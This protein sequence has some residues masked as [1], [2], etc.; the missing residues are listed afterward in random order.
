MYD[1]LLTVSGEVNPYSKVEYNSAR[2]PI[3][4][5]EKKPEYVQL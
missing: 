3:E 2:V 4:L 1:K 5:L